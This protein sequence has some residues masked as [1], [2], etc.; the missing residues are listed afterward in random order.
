[1]NFHGSSEAKIKVENA[2]GVTLR[3]SHWDHEVRYPQKLDNASSAVWYC[4]NCI[5][6]KVILFAEKRMVAEKPDSER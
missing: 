6:N 4:L 5:K 1:M 2:P 3:I